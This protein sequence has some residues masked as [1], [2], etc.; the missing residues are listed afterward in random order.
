MIHDGTLVV[1]RPMQT[2]I[3]FWLFLNKI[4]WRNEVT[5]IRRLQTFLVITLQLERKKLEG[6]K[7][8]YAS[9]QGSRCAY[10]KMGSIGQRL[11][12]IWNDNRNHPFSIDSHVFCKFVYTPHRA[13][14]LPRRQLCGN[15][16][17]CCY[18]PRVVVVCNNSGGSVVHNLRALASTVTR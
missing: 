10:S 11:R 6:C 9:R 13:A 18:H 8:V 3:F 17:T 1:S 15:T 16:T 2:W 7:L 12:E 5:P 4:Y 14:L